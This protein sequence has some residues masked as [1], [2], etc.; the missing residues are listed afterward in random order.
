MLECVLEAVSGCGGEA[1]LNGLIEHENEDV[2]ARA[3]RLREKYF[4]STDKPNRSDA[5]VIAHR[6][7]QGHIQELCAD[8]MSSDA[9]TVMDAMDAMDGLRDIVTAVDGD[10][11]TRV[12]GILTECGGR[13]SL[14]VLEK[15]ANG[16]IASRAEGLLV[17]LRARELTGEEER[18]NVE[19]EEEG[20]SEEKSEEG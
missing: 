5:S 1:S 13:A 3:I 17:L 15:Y 11:I 9:Q 7:Q 8:I 16:E 10:L 14:E 18:E 19:E 12:D 6:V 4:S 2:R 20:Q